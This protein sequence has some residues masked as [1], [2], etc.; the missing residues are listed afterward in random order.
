MI[1]HNAEIGYL[2]IRQ[3]KNDRLIMPINDITIKCR[4]KNAS[5]N[6]RKKSL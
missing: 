1:E 6:N 3:F 5:T 4:N 2:G